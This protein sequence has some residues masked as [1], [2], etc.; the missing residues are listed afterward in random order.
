M[1]GQ[2]VTPF[3]YPDHVFPK[4]QQ[5]FT[6][7]PL[8]P[9]DK[10]KKIEAGYHR[11]VRQVSGGP[12]I[13]ANQALDKSVSSLHR[14]LSQNIQLSRERSV[15][16]E[17]Q[18]SDVHSNTQINVDIMFK[19]AREAVDFAENHA[20][21]LPEIIDAAVDIVAL[22]ADSQKGVTKFKGAAQYM[23]A[24]WMFFGLFGRRV[25]PQKALEMFYESAKS[26]FTRA[27]YRIGSEFEKAGDVAN[28]LTF[29]NQ[30]L[31]K[32]DSACLYRMAMCNLR[33]HLGIEVNKEQGMQYLYKAS[34]TSDPDCP[35]SS[36]VFGLIQLGEIPEVS[37]PDPSFP[38]DVGIAAMERAAWLGFAP[39]L[40]RMGMAWQG[41]ERGYD[42][43]IALRYFHIA[44]RQQQYLRYKGDSSAGLGGSAEVEISKWLLCGSENIFPPNEEFA[45]YF[46]K[47]ACDQ[48]N[49]IGQ[50]AVGYFHEV[51]IAVKQDIQDALIWYGLAA[52][53]GSADAT[54][55]LRQLNISRQNTITKQQHKKVLLLKGRGSMRHFRRK[56]NKQPT[57]DPEYPDV[58][59][60]STVVPPE[61]RPGSSASQKSQPE[62]LR[63]SIRS[64]STEQ[65]VSARSSPISRH[66]NN[67]SPDSDVSPSRRSR[68][69]RLSLPTD[70][71]RLQIQPSRSP[72]RQQYTPLPARRGVSTM[73]PAHQVQSLRRTSSPVW[74][75]PPQQHG[76]PG[77]N[78]KPLSPTLD[79][80]TRKPS[81]KLNPETM[82]VLS[83]SPE[84]TPEP[85]LQKPIEE[86]RKVSRFSVMG[87]F[88]GGSNNAEEPIK[89]EP[90]KEASE[91]ASS[92]TP[93][94]SPKPKSSITPPPSIQEQ[95]VK[96]Q[97]LPSISK[98]DLTEP[99]QLSPLQSRHPSYPQSSSPTPKPRNSQLQSSAAVDSRTLRSTPDI[100]IPSPAR[101]QSNSP[102]R[103][104]PN[105]QVVQAL[106]GSKGYKTFEEM[107]IPMA[108][109][110]KGDC[111]VM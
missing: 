68:K 17:S 5:P 32:G 73:L 80:P 7:L 21:L 83:P 96:D 43:T 51:G 76:F 72:P 84:S 89:E 53:N 79:S 30:G 71:Y 39:A 97:S 20:G 34:C 1:K 3:T 44:S 25:D 54:E 18:A 88:F 26:G 102:V 64:P 15:S 93:T 77:V 78:R 92:T 95:S 42:S 33:G 100:G 105:V 74:T 98:I 29:F 9:L 11:L 27:L 101:S 85:E 22:V 41:G 19:W 35:Q 87:L 4:V 50:F 12:D 110:D 63:S 48:G 86:P 94:P 62:S 58:L 106:P 45:Y 69:D 90:S 23:V 75:S 24:V 108:Q 10:I 37:D 104:N 31:Q 82:P 28:A 65:Q 13:E 67:S 81:V 38:E 99:K 56:D 40:L 107:G 60:S 46:A 36:Y 52:S 91:P 66:S 109:K 47:L 16:G 49:A 6:G 61:S 59:R 14:R 55:R 2:Q 70:A 103:R 111:I 57:P 8:A